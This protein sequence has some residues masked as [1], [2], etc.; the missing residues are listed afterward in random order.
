VA[1]AAHQRWKMFHLNVTTTFLNEPLTNE[2]YM[3]QLE[4][5]II[6]GKEYKVHKIMEALYGLH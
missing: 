3:T 4:G 5:D 6:P 1:F 2:M